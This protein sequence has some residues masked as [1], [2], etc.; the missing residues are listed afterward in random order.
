M[1]PSAPRPDREDRL[2][3]ALIAAAA[4]QPDLLVPLQEAADRWQDRLEHDGLDPTLATVLRLACDG[5]WMCDLFGLAAPTADRRHAVAAALDG[6]ARR[7][8]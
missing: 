7:P 8:S 2:G 4:A 5:L 1:E 6:L 3:A